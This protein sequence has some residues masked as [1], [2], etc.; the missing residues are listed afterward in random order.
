MMSYKKRRLLLFV[1]TL[2]S[3]AQI[4]FVKDYFLLLSVSV[5]GWWDNLSILQGLFSH[6]EEEDKLSLVGART[7]DTRDPCLVS[8]FKQKKPRNTFRK[9]YIFFFPRLSLSYLM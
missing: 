4:E 7:H 9:L 1:K 8:I 5:V 6:S 2:Y 3:K